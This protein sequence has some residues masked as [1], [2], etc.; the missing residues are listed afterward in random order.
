MSNNISIYHDLFCKYTLI[1]VD[2]TIGK[3]FKQNIIFSSFLVKKTICDNNITKWK[4]NEKNYLFNIRE[5]DF[6][7]PCMN[8]YLF[9]IN[10]KVL[11]N[12]ERFLFLY[13]KK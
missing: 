3:Y 2:L 5:F 12:K 13:R 9:E 8:Q 1:D 4:T 7:P 11:N 10:K 6:L